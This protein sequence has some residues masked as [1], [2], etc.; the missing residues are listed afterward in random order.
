MK[1]SQTANLGV[2]GKTGPIARGL[3]EG[4]QRCED[5][6]APLQQG[7]LF[8]APP[9]GHALTKLQSLVHR[10]EF[11]SAQA[12]AGVIGLVL[13]QGDA[14]RLAVSL[15]G[16]LSRLELTDG[17]SLLLPAGAVP[18]LDDLFRF[19]S[20]QTFVSR[21]SGDWVIEML[22]EGRIET[23]FQPIVSFARPT[24]PFAYEGLLRGLEPDGSLISPSAIFHAARDANVIFQLDRSARLACIDA[25]VAKR[26]ETNVFINFTPNSVYDPAF[27]LRSTVSA[28]ATAGL[29]PSRFVFE[30][31][32]SDQ[33][34]DVDHLLGILSF[35]RRSGF[36]VALDDL[37]AG[38]SSL[39]LLA[40]LRPDFVKL[41]MELIRGIDLDPYKAVVVEKLLELA[42]DVGAT[43]VVEG[44]ETE[45]EWRW[46]RE[47]GADLAQGFL[48]ARPAALP[49][50]PFSDQPLPRD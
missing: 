15:S 29:D 4:C 23:H 7:T 10:L 5:L 9:P 8:I 39:N 27:C 11:E 28:V 14:R 48:C 25:V 33:V 41:D 44:V 21:A 31:T 16:A 2:T 47:H 38:Y 22:R 12:P 3:P 49:P 35:Y 30:V 26:V 43:S 17:K 40:R 42:R 13:G 50:I 32:E 37:G 1:P 34:K 20:L 18:S 46:A 36:R 6:P 19:E 45:G 24:E